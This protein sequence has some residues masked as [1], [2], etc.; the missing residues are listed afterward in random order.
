MQSSA[1]QQTSD[2]PRRGPGA[3]ALWQRALAAA[4]RGKPALASQW[5]RRALERSDPLREP[6]AHAQIL[7]TLA[8]AQ[9]EL[10]DADTAV[11]MLDEALTTD[12]SRLPAVLT[13][14]GMVLLRAGHPDALDALDQAIDA[15]SGVRP[16][17]AQAGAGPSDLASALLNRGVMRMNRGL[18][19]AAS[20]DT[21][22]AARAAAEAGRPTVV[23]M[24]RH[25][26]GYIRFL[27]GDLPG[28]LSEMAAA[29][30]LI[31]G[32]MPGVPALD[33]ARVLLAAGLLTEARDYVDAALAA[34]QT[35]R[36]RADLAEALLVESDISLQQR[37]LGHARAGARRAARIYAARG[38][39]PAT[40][41]AR[42]RELR[43]WGPDAA[44]AGAR[45]ARRR[46]EA[47]EA[48]AAELSAAQLP[49]QAAEARLLQAEA[50]VDARDLDPARSLLVGP[51][52][53]RAGA[54][55][56]TRLHTRLLAA[57][58]ALD[59][60]RPRA[61]LREIRSGL[62]DLARFQAQFGSPDMQAG[63]AVHGRELARIGL[64]TAV[65][66]GSP[67]V[68]LQWLERSRAVST[69]LQAVRPPA[70]AQ[71]AEDLGAL[72]VA[73]DQSRQ[74]AL[75]G[76]P[77][78]AS[79]RRVAEL[80]HRVRTRSWTLG[81]S[82]TVDRPPTITDVQRALAGHG[83]GTV[84]A[85]F[86]GSGRD[87]ALVIGERRAR[88]L[89]LGDSD[90]T[91]ERARRVASDLELLADLRLPP[92][93]RSVA[94]RSLTSTLNELSA[95]LV[96]PV[97]RWLDGGPLLLVAVGSTAALPWSLVPALRERP[98]SVTSSVTRAVA[99]LR[100]A[101]RPAQQNGVLVV[102]AP[103]VPNGVK[104]A[105]SVARLHPGARMLAGP[106]ATGAAVLQAMP[107]DGLLHVAA[108]G[109]HESD[110]PLFSGLMLA[111][112]LLFGYDVAPNPALPQQV[113]MSSCDVGQVGERP[114]GE[115]LGL[116]AALVRSGI[117]TAVAATSRIADPV[118][119][120][121]T[122][123]Y[124]Q[125]LLSGHGPAGA[126]AV[127]IAKAGSDPELPAPLTCFGA[128]A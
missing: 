128:G 4:D 66:I 32:P 17:T 63:A 126:L 44:G 82:G 55:L 76:R 21:E 112:G 1:G 118:A 33:R 49:E 47:A 96:E 79:A 52:N 27:A 71:L 100:P 50:L 88:Y 34:F 15:L 53:L 84:L 3:A 37:D 14:R 102:A 117:R 24:A 115:P 104:E 22:R 60:G 36:A 87:H 122:V 20:A 67:A 39:V 28:A 75:A 43:A 121:T 108:H 127:A 65:D 70:D 30:E 109:H 54:S 46:A 92:A 91:T 57:R 5:C 93:L 61:G 124:H 89:C 98:L 95:T 38:N 110:N 31:P 72:R 42:V 9:S 103:G 107:A 97:A 86:H 123:A 83:G 85:F 2:R 74:A 41:L 58:I 125:A 80:Q 8:C 68:I 16:E 40:L 51:E 29:S 78:P 90:R 105:R 59:T 73:F 23:H 64:R 48:L 81:G 19:A 113:V 120:E 7:I 119:E 101:M 25:N 77:D 106:D 116:V 11:A 111:D 6:G 13:A 62:D 18:L 114:G 45:S 99:S 10:G 12:P 35:N 69:R 26:L 56:G 94:A